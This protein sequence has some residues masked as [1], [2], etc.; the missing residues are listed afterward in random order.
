MLDCTF[1]TRPPTY[2]A[3]PSGQLLAASGDTTIPVYLHG[4]CRDILKTSMTNS[5]A[6]S[7]LGAMGKVLHLY[8]GT[9]Q[10][11]DCATGELMWL[12]DASDEEHW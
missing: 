7:L 11:L 10:Y 9:C 3:S 6:S 1:S 2:Q 12:V 8:T 4:R 5:F